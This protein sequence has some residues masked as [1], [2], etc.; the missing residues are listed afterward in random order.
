MFNLEKLK[1]IHKKEIEL[2]K[3]L[4]EELIAELNNKNIDEDV[5][6]ELFQDQIIEHDSI[7]GE[8]YG[9]LKNSGDVTVCLSCRMVE[10][11]SLEI[12]EYEVL[13][14]SAV[15]GKSHNFWMNTP[16]NLANQ[17]NDL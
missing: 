15:I 13:G 6:R 3:E 8:C 1:S 4:K 10:G 12:D 7:C 5:F 2:T 14:I 16:D 9:Q 11:A 17:D